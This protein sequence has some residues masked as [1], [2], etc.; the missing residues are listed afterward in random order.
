[1][2]V[3][4]LRYRWMGGHVLPLNSTPPPSKSVINGLLVDKS[5]WRLRRGGQLGRQWLLDNQCHKFSISSLRVRDV[6][7]QSLVVSLSLI[8][9]SDLS[10]F[11]FFSQ[12]APH[13]Y[14]M[15][16]FKLTKYIHVISRPCF[17]T[18]LCVCN[19][20]KQYKSH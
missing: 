4:A 15:L 18:V 19:I 11:L 5:P 14:I 1:M 3:S 8:L 10:L 9:I 16:Y 6:F 13:Y 12:Q 7:S 2:C 20:K 17:Y